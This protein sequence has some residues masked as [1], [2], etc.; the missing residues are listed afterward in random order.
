VRDG[1]IAISKHAEDAPIFLISI[2]RLSKFC[3][4]YAPMQN[5]PIFSRAAHH[6]IHSCV[7]VELAQ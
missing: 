4:S 7:L 5:I 6:Y 2:K 3:F 1:F